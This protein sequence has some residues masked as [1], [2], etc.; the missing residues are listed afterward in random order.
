MSRRQQ[1]LMELLLARQR[2]SVDELSRHFG[3]TDMTVRRDLQSLEDQGLLTRTHG[4]CVLR[5]APVQEQ[6]FREKEQQERDAKETIARRVVSLLSD[7]TS[8]YLDTGTTCAMIAHL[9]PGLRRGLQVFTN[10][11]PAALALFG[12]DGIEVVVLGGSLGRHSPDL[13]GDYSV[14]RLTGLSLDLAILGTD[15]CDLDCGEFYSADLATATLSQ[16]AQ[17]RAAS[18]WLCLDSTKFAKRALAVAG[19]LHKG[20]RVFTDDRLRPE[21]ARQLARHGVQIANQ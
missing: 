12:A 8:L 14:Q 4:G 6:P 16:T 19:R 3:V 11:L 1:L 5:N 18:T 21:Q 9:L 13:T 7:G 2:L 10:N 17:Q 15:A 20:L